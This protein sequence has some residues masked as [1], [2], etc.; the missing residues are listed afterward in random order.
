M[1]AE[2]QMTPEQ[3]ENAKTIMPGAEDVIESGDV[4]TI[5]DNEGN[6]IAIKAVEC[7]SV[8]TFIEAFSKW[9][10]ARKKGVTGPVLEALSFELERTFLSLPTRI[11]RELPDVKN[12]GVAVGHRRPA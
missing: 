6:E 11:L 10:F 7:P 4:M 3:F 2:M 8:V 9:H 5:R 1:E 12:L